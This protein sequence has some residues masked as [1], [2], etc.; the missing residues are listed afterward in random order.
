MVPQ[1]FWELILGY[2]ILVRTDYEPLTHIK[3]CKDSHG[4]LARHLDTLLE[5]NPLIVYTSG[6][7][8][9]VADTLS[10]VLPVL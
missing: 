8:N 3:S 2:A 7:C 9:K 1:T 5:F 10:C 4:R 6:P